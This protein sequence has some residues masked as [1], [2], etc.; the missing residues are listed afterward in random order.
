MAHPLNDTQFEQLITAI[1]WSQRQLEYPRRK[2]VEAVR[3]FVGYHY[4]ENGAVKR[5]PVPFLALA[6][7][8]YVRQL[9]ARA[10]RALITTARQD[11][12]HVAANL[13]L[14]I[15]QV[16]PE[17]GLTQ[18]LRKLVTEAL[19]S[20]GIVKCGLH[21]V[22]QILGHE[23]GESF[24]DLVTIDDYFCDMSAK[25]FRE[26]DYEGNDY[27]LDYEEVMDSKW[28]DKSARPFL[29]ADDYTIVGPSGAERAEGVSVNETAEQYKKKIHLRDVWLPADN[30]VVTY[31]VTSQKR[32]KV[33]ERDAPHGPYYKLGFTDVPGN[34][35]PLPPVS[36]W[37]DLHELSN[38]LYRKLGN[39]AD[40][41]KRVLGFPGGNNDEAENFKKAHDGDGIT[42]TGQE[43]KTLE[44]GG[45]DARTLAFYL[46]TRD[47]QSYFAGNV[48][49][50]GGLSPQ[51]ETVGQ[52]R[53]LSEAAGAQLRDM[54]DTTVGVVKE[55]F[56]A[57][58]Y[59]EWSDPIKRRMLEK[60]IP[61]TDLSITSEFGPEHKQ[62]RFDEYDLNIDVYSMQ[63]DSPNLKLQKLGLVMQTYV[64]PL[65]PLIQQEGGSIDV[66]KI[67]QLVAKYSD[68]PELSQIVTFMEPAGSQGQ[69]EGP[70]APAQTERR[71]VREG[72]PGMT[73]EG[74]SR[75]LQSRLLSGEFES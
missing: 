66:Q 4:F 49:T 54:A 29:K 25:S 74:A 57:L 16:P 68:L 56:Q 20:F 19:F 40:S 75:E 23:Y 24:V 36:L 65:A 38:S 32:I 22:G 26:I 18:T 71:Y 30:I 3:Q 42:Y 5:V 63:D 60:P 35:L 46:Q 10:P 53:L 51:T 41:F 43:P 70:S 9:A 28:P 50:L 52:D 55:I 11:L 44:A 21:T 69:G 12:W 58:A 39:E 45:V 61:G 33:T 27:W 31:G 59:Y 13:E 37:R 72:R 34:L 17:I 62:G 15:N 14:A 8:I 47:L 67:M 6:V 48:D 1:N 7:Q 2:R 73:R 64:L